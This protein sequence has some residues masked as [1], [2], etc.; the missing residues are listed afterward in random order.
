MALGMDIRLR[1][2]AAL[3]ILGPWTKAK[4]TLQSF[5]PNQNYL[6]GCC[7]NDISHLLERMVE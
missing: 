5:F 3:V 7:E 1:A 4:E 6:R 2:G